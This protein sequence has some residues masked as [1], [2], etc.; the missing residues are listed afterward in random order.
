MEGALNT[1]IKVANTLLF[2]RRDTALPIYF[3]TGYLYSIVLNAKF[4]TGSMMK[5]KLK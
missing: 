1:L 5:L 4:L 3:Y 2:R